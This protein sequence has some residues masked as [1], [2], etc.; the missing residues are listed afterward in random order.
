MIYRLKQKLPDLLVPS[1]LARLKKFYHTVCY[2]FEVRK[3][4]L[5][6]GNRIIH[7]GARLKHVVFC[8]QGNHN[9]IEIEPG[10]VL[11]GVRIK[12]AGSGHHLSIGAGSF[13]SECRFFF[14]DEGCR[15]VLGEKGF[16]YDSKISA[17]EANTKII[18]GSRCVC[19]EGSDIRTTDA[20]SLIDL[21][22]GKRNNPAQDVE[23]GPRV[24]IAEGAVVLKG[25]RIGE[26]S[27]VGTRSV[28]TKSI[29]S[30]CLA[31]GNPARVLRENVSW[32]WE[33][34]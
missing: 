21:A 1:S 2:P 23:I 31:A 20:H 10:A 34:S 19:A 27:I 13:V 5:G 30:N 3:K 17:A 28:V 29:P 7:R 4:I 8:V 33:R 16:F 32:K 11:E 25:V 12:V 18:I 24:W 14:E 9:T 22:S 6:H 26:G 15:I